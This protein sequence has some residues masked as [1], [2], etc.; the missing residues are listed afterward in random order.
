MKSDLQCVT[1]ASVGIVG[2]LLWMYRESVV[3]L[4]SRYKMPVL[5]AATVLSF[6]SAA[7]T[8]EDVGR[9][10]LGFVV[11]IAILFVAARVVWR[12]FF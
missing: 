7:T 2:T 6:L 12:K 3:R 4:I 1:L 5:F 9:I 10:L 11:P 8:P